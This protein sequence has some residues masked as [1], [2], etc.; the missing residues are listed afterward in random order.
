MVGIKALDDKL[1]GTTRWS[2]FER[3]NPLRARA[4]VELW[5]AFNQKNQL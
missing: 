3:D 1:M 2:E 5:A 4:Y